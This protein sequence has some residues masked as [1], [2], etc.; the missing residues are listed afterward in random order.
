M[1]AHEALCQGSEMYSS[2]GRPEQD[3]GETMAK[4]YL[5]DMEEHVNI[6]V[7]EGWNDIV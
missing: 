5:V 1:G 7:H 6:G 4:L 3:F 2:F